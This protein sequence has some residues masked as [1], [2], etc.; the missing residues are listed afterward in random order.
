MTPLDPKDPKT[1]INH[2]PPVDEALQAELTRVGGTVPAGGYAGQ[3]IYKL[4]FGQQHKEF[5]GGK[6]RLFFR[7]SRIPKRFK[8]TRFF[9]SNALLPKLSEWA[10]QN[11]KVD[12]F[13][14]VNIDRTPLSTRIHEEFSGDYQQLETLTIP[15]R[16]YRRMKHAPEISAPAGWVFVSEIEEV[17]DIGRQCWYVLRWLAAPDVESRASWDRNRFEFEHYLPEVGGNVPVLDFNG[18]YPEDGVYTAYT[19]IA[20]Y[21]G[22]DYR[23]YK[24][25]KP[26]F[27]TVVQPVLDDI[28]TG[29]LTDE[30]KAERELKDH[31]ATAES[32]MKVIDK[33]E[34]EWD[35]FTRDAAPAFAG[36]A[37]AYQPGKNSEAYTKKA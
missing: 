27:S 28:E 35:H 30:E 32:F 16:D 21:V 37:R 4:V 3:P 29:K 9:V 11:P 1:W 6:K 12:D 14:V 7:D 20:D 18:A 34:E 17:I 33:Q 13:G 15:E 10:Q 2:D 24:Y 5:I 31:I 26:S 23:E 19:E 25:L 36:N 22:K 8:V